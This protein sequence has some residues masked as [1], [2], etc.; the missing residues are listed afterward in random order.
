MTFPVTGALVR[1]ATDDEKPDVVLG[2]KSVV[3]NVNEGVVRTG[4]VASSAG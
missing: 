3:G 1:A 2:G 4:E